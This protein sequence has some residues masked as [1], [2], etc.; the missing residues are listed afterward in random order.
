MLPFSKAIDEFLDINN[1]L[2]LVPHGEDDFDESVSVSISS[3]HH[4]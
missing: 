1:P 2:I 4:M 3:C